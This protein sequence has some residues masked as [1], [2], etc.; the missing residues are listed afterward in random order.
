MTQQLPSAG[1]MDRLAGDGAGGGRPPT[2]GELTGPANELTVVALDVVELDTLADDALLIG[3]EL[4]ADDDDDGGAL[5]AD[6]LLLF[7]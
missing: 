1:D 2:A 5:F 4:D 3:V 6:G 7:R